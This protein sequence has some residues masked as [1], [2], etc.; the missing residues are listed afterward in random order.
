[1]AAIHAVDRLQAHLR[2]GGHV[3]QHRKARRRGHDD[4]D[5]ASVL[6]EEQCRRQVV[7]DH[8]HL[9]PD[10]VAQGGTGARYGMWVTNV[11]VRLLNSSICRWVMPPVPELLKQY[12]PGFFVNTS[13]KFLKS[14]AGKLGCTAITFGVAA[15]LMIDV[16]SVCTLYGDLR[17][18]R[19]I[20]RHRGHSGHAQ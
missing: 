8:Q 2:E 9:P 13:G 16:K 10:R 7:E 18:D 19:R 14:R 4:R 1:M 3:G 20:G 12:L 15:T 5:Q 11:L 17:I 6:D